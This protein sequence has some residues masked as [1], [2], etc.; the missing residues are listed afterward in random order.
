MSCTWSWSSFFVL[1]WSQSLYVLRFLLA[2]VSRL[3][4]QPTSRQ[5]MNPDITWPDRNT[6]WMWECLCSHRLKSEWKS[7]EQTGQS[8]PL[9]LIEQFSPLWQ[10]LLFIKFSALLQL[11]SSSFSS[12]VVKM[13]QDRLR[14]MLFFW[15]APDAALAV[16]FWFA[17]AQLVVDSCASCTSCTRQRLATQLGQCLQ[18]FCACD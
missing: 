17:V 4:P 3:Q 13:V 15:N 12:Q 18:D 16:C 6:R 5:R 10:R 2:R 11:M 7:K 1:L 8:A 9:Q 14:H